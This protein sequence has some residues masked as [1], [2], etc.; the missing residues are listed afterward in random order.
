MIKIGEFAKKRLKEDRENLS[1][2]EVRDL[3]NAVRQG[4]Y[5]EGIMKEHLRDREEAR[6]RGELVDNSQPYGES[7]DQ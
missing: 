4:E 5:A 1:D 2:D 3:E 6:K 7:Q